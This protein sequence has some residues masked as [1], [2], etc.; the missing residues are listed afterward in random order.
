MFKTV[1]NKMV[2]KVKQICP[3]EFVENVKQFWKWASSQLGMLLIFTEVAYSYLPMI[4]AYISEGAA[5]FL[6]SLIIVLRVLR[7]KEA[8]SNRRR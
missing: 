4:H 8:P 2:N 7:L 3:I 5:G 6:G 1:Y